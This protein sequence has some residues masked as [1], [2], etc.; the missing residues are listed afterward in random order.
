MTKKSSELM[1]PGLAYIADNIVSR[2]NILGGP[3]EAGAAWAKGLNLPKSRDTIFFAGCGYQYVSGLESLMS[4]M[5]KMD[6]SPLGTEIPMGLAGMPKKMGID[7]ASVYNKL[8]VKNDAAEGQ[9]LRDAVR[10]LR[11]LKIDFGYL[12]EEEPC[13]GGLLHYAG[14]RDEF[15]TNS[16]NAFTRFKQYGIKTIIGIVPS[17]TYTLHSLLPKYVDS[18]IKVRHF[19]QVVL[20][21]ISSLNLKFPGDIKVTYH[22]PCQL[23]RYMKLVE[24]PRKILA[25][26]NGIKLLE[27]N[28]TNREWS[29]CCGG[30]GGFE[31]V[32]PELSEILAVNRAKELAETGA[33]AIITSCPGCIMQ[34]KDG[35]K[36]L[37]K[38]KVEVMDLASVIAMSLG[39]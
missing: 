2:Q 37:G 17:C 7:L 4:L 26:I 23:S 20:E 12:A 5:R 9:V 36:K 35:L 22:D 24:E 19:S 28:W 31:A 21:G 38:E 34:I 13:C 39:D 14:L 18:D 3:R 33:E 27:T 1:P 6:K 10:V 16:K 15:A 11:A 32:F 8:T 25:A 29:T 30:G